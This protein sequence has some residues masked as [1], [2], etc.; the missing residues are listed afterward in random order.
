MKF[1]CVGPG[2]NAIE[3]FERLLQACEFL[4]SKK[5][6]S[7]LVAGMNTARHQAYQV[8]IGKGFWI[9][10]EGVVMQKPNEPAYNRPDVFII[11]DLR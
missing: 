7:R 5:N 10:F 8:M 9:D 2:R 11:D 3:N 6:V 4:A 1:G